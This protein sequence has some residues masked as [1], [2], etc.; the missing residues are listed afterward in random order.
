[1]FQKLFN[2][3]N[4]SCGI[5]ISYFAIIVAIIGFHIGYKRIFWVIY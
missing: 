3:F 2:P 4:D 1:M 5:N